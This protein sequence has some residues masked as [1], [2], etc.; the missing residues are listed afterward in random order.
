MKMG[1]VLSPAGCLGLACPGDGGER[2]SLEVY[3]PASPCSAFHRFE[4]QP[5]GRIQRQLVLNERL[6]SVPDAMRFFEEI[7]ATLMKGILPDE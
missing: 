1:L 2:Q 4:A 3:P 7:T 5:E 6:V